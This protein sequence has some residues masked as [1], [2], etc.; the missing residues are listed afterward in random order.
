MLR[1]G[2]SLAEIGDVLGHRHLQTTK[3]YAKV[4]IEAL[5][6]LVRIPAKLNS[7]SDDVDRERRRGAW[8]SSVAQSFNIVSARIGFRVFDDRVFGSGMWMHHSGAARKVWP[9]TA[10]RAV[11]LI[12]A[13]HGVSLSIRAPPG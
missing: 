11:P 1:K 4:D 3:I 10:G 9:W 7:K 13:L 8:W 2:A 5:R 12:G 6:A